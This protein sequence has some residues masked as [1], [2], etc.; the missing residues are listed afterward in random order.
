M[1]VAQEVN[2]LKEKGNACLKENKVTEAVLFYTQ[3]IKLDETNYLLY[4]NRSYAFLKQD[5]IPLAFE[6]A[7]KVI[8]LRPDCAKGYFRKGEVE[9]AAKYWDDAL[10][11]YRVALRL[12]PN[13]PMILKCIEKTLL[14]LNQE[15]KFDEQIPWLGAGIGIILGVSLVLADYTL[16]SK[17]ALNNPLTMLLV[18]CVCA[19]IGYFIAKSI[20]YFQKQDKVDLLSG[21]KSSL[22]GDNSESTEASEDEPRKHAKY[23]KA[24]ARQRYRKGKT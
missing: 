15:K 5:V 11:S 23:S 2:E 22:F 21:D 24:Q 1:S 6:D 3:A 9:F 4:S 8:S 19:F 14:N 16:A 18:P 13:D 10:L 17:K 7:L 12:Q 20:R